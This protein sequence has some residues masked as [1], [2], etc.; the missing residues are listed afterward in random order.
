MR[1]VGD[2]TP[3]PDPSHAAWSLVRDL[4]RADF[5]S[6]AAVVTANGVLREPARREV[7]ARSGRAAG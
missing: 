6:R 3:T 2:G 1:L 7:A 4:S 5:G